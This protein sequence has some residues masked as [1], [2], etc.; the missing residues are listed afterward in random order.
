MR[1]IVACGV[2]IVG[3]AAIGGA[4]LAQQATGPAHVLVA[5]S[6]V[7]WGEAP[8]VFEKGA[9]FAVISG[10]PSKPGLYVV[11]LKMPAG[12]KTNTSRC[13]R[14]PSPWAWERSSTSQ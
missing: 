7:K 2:V 14:V 6:E 10:D 11:R 8:P 13:F 1:K 9:S 4:A 3:L 5:P 12:Y